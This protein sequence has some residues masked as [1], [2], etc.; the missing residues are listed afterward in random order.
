MKIVLI[1]DQLNA[2]GAEKVLVFIANMLHTKGHEVSVVL[3]LGKA[4]LDQQINKAIP[5]HYLHRRGRFDLAAMKKLK[6]WVK[7]ADI[8]HIHS[9]YNL[10]YYM[11]AKILLAINK[12]KVVFHE[13]MPRFTLDAFTKFLFTR[14][15][16]YAAVLQSMTNWVKNDK[17]V[18]PQHIFYLPNAVAAPT[19]PI[20]RKPTKGKIVMVGNFWHLKNQLFALDVLLQLPEYCTLDIYGM[21]YEKEY[22]QQLI[23]KINATG[24]THRVR[25]IEGVT[26]IYSVLGEYDFAWHTSTSET[27]PLVLIEYM[28]AHLPFVC[29]NTGDVAAVLQQSLPQIVIDGFDAKHWAAIVQQQLMDT[30]QRAII[31]TQLQQ[32]LQTNYSESA[33]YK[34]LIHMYQSVLESA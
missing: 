22:H 29:S 3:Y 6:T 5:I 4:A 18:K 33:Y 10:R 30:E 2:G 12:P 23:E 20:T 24:L 9:R 31:Q 21:V 32:I 25:L 34:S 7:D 1:N 19:I 28:H 8:V 14:V 26:N 11:M 13:H 17:L 15:Q 16:A 27:G